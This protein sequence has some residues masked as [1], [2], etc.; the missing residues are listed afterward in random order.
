M[1]GYLGG[2]K[3]REILAGNVGRENVMRNVGWENLH[4]K[5]IY[6]HTTTQIKKHS[7]NSTEIKIHLS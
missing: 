3:C 4:I 5:M 6:Q 2:R 7:Y 1:D